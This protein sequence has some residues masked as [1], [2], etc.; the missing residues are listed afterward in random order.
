MAEFWLDGDKQKSFEIAIKKAARQIK[1]WG[2]A[3]IDFRFQ[4]GETHVLAVKNVGNRVECCYP[5]TAARIFDELLT[6]ALL[7]SKK[8]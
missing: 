1:S 7:Q 6:E 3:Y 5:E 2:T 8:E 4:N